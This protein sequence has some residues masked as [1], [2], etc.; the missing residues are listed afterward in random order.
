MSLL[1]TRLYAGWAR[2]HL[3]C[4]AEGVE[5]RFALTFDDGPNPD[6][7]PSLL[8][9][10]PRFGARATFFVLAGNVRRHPE[11]V[12]RLVAEGHEAASHGEV[13]WPLPF[14]PPWM[15]Q[16]E[17]RRS[18]T[19]IE[20]ASGV[21]PTHYRPP[22]GF[23]AP[24]QARFVRYLGYEPVLGDVYPEDAHS[25]GV[26]RIVS[27]V[28]RRLTAGSILI[29]HDGS[30]LGPADRSQTILAAERILEWAAARGL[31]AVTVRELLDAESA[32]RPSSG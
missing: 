23:M 13:H 20:G 28:T 6:A 15:I 18:A 11:L 24:G 8:D 25:P 31:R 26:E 17:L 5:G 27:R 7:T 19:A 29:L 22:F 9:L 10:L 4:R 2:R 21:R 1:H 32:D 16:R 3:R 14:L 12:A 30:P